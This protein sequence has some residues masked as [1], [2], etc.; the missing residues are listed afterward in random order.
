MSRGCVFL[1]SVDCILSWA[2][3]ERA[4]ANDGRR[5]RRRGAGRLRNFI[6][7]YNLNRAS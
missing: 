6:V 3:A 7:N 2:A 4:V 5:R 1:L